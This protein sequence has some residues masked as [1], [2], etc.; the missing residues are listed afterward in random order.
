MSDENLIEKY[1][2]SLRQLE[3]L[4]RNYYANPEPNAAERAAYNRRK[5]RAEEM[6]TR[7]Y[8][9]LQESRSSEGHFWHLNLDRQ[10]VTYSIAVH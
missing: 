2:A 7:F 8:A 9:A 10:L 6:R 3:L 1:A 4:D 5:Q